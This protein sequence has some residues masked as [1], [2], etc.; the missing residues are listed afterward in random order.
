MHATFHDRFWAVVAHFPIVT[1]IWMGYLLYCKFVHQYELTDLL[2]KYQNASWQALPLTPI[3]LTLLSVPIALGIQRMQKSY[4]LAR[5]NAHQA[6]LFNI[7]LLQCYA[8]IFCIAVVGLYLRRME[9][10]L[11]SGALGFFVGVNC[12]IQATLGIIT[13][14]NGRV[15]RYWR[16]GRK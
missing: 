16:L 9:I 11:F 15:Y 12:L 5:N 1:M 4:P 13:A 6:Y 8:V 2:S 14:W 3:A 10:F 7:W